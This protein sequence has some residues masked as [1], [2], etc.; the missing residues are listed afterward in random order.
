MDASDLT[1]RHVQ[2]VNNETL[3]SQLEDESEFDQDFLDATLQRYLSACRSG[4]D[5]LYSNNA[6]RF[7]K[8]L[9]NS[10]LR[11]LS[12]RLSE[13]P[14]GH[15]ILVHNCHPGF[16]QTDMHRQLLQAMDYETFKE[17]VAKGRFGNEELISVEEG[18]DTPVWLCLVPPGLIPSGLLW[19]RRQRM[20]Y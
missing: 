1:H 7:S 6:Y 3:R 8:A 14:P 13:R 15:Q 18:A 10:S 20:S 11:L 12:E 17:Q 5:Q 9:L 4:H 16:V 19:A 2:N